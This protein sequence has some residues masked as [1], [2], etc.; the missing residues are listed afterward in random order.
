MSTTPSSALPAQS[1][2]YD[3]DEIDATL[4]LSQISLGKNSSV[5]VDDVAAR[6]DRSDSAPLSNLVADDPQWHP[7]Q[8]LDYIRQQLAELLTRVRSYSLMVLHLKKF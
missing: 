8:A 6:L 1:S 7:S 3:E 5:E 4:R 2:P